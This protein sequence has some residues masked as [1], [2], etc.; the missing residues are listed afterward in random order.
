MIFLRAGQR[1]EAAARGLDSL[2]QVIALLFTQSQRGDFICGG[3][4][5]QK[6]RG[7]LVT[8]TR[9]DLGTDLFWRDRFPGIDASI[10]VR[11]QTPPGSGGI[12]PAVLVGLAVEVGIE[13]PIDLDA[14]LV[15]APHIDFVVVVGV[16]KPTQALAGRIEHDPPGNASLDLGFDAAFVDFGTDWACRSRRPTAAV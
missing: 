11:I 7:I 10:L 5:S 3:Q 1:R 16:E 8:E 4:Q 2:G 13:V 14:I 12:Q 9:D 15:V 6:S